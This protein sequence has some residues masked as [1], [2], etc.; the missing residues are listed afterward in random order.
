MISS[1]HVLVPHP[2]ACLVVRDLEERDYAHVI[3]YWGQADPTFLDRMGVDPAKI[4]TPQAR[5]A[6][7]RET[8]RTPDAQK[9]VMDFVWEVNGEPIGYTT[10]KRLRYGDESDIHLH[11]WAPVARG[12]GY[13][14]ELFRA[15]LLE[16]FRRFSLQKIICEPSAANPAP[17]GMLRALGARVA[18]TYVTASSD[19]AR[20]K[21][22][23]RY[24]FLRTEFLPA[25]LGL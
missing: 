17:N 10:L 16:A 3:D 13:G 18:R 4:P 7:F 11:M 24:E 8:A 6:R 12:K 14:R 22:V 25:E 15:S 2:E 21:E 23:N 20:E 1:S 5:T 19:I 9:T